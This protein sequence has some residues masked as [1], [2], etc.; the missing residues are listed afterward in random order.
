MS[1]SFANSRKREARQVIR[2]HLIGWMYIIQVSYW[3]VRFRRSGT[4]ENAAERRARLP[5]DDERTLTNVAEKRSNSVTK[6]YLTFRRQ[7]SRQMA[8]H[9]HLGPIHDALAAWMWLDVPEMY[10]QGAEDLQR[11][12]RASLRNS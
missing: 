12:K 2:I 11:P 5:T 4:A 7:N 8:F 9:L 6:L 3:S 10:D 1:E